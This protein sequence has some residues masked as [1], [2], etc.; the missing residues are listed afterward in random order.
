[1]SVQKETVETTDMAKFVQELRADYGQTRNLYLTLLGL[2]RLDAVNLIKRVEKGFSFNV[3]IRFQRNVALPMKEIAEWV[4]IPQTTLN[5]RRAQGR[6]QP[7]E[8]DRVLR[9][10]RVFGKALELFEGDAGAA[11]HWLA[12]PQRA[13]GGAVPMGLAKTDLGSREVEDLIERI[14]HGVFS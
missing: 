5:R 12:S 13:L 1:M 2:P 11:R 10:S 14:E 7:D 8:S 9:A 3:L 4:Q 6:L